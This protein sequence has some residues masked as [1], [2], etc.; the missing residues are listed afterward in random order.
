[1]CNKQFK[2]CDFGSATSEQVDLS[3]A[4]RNKILE[5]EEEFEKQTTLMYRPP[6]MID[7][8]AKRLIN[9]KV[10]IWMLGCVLYTL[11]YAQHPFQEG[12]QLAVVNSRYTIPEDT[13]FDD[14]FKGFIQAI[15]IPDPGSRP[16]I[17]QLIHMLDNYDN[18]NFALTQPTSTKPKATGPRKKGLDRDIT[19][20]EIEEEMRRMREEMAKNPNA[21]F[22]GKRVAPRAPV[23]R[24]APQVQRAAPPA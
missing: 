8:Y 15:L 24:Q 7:L 1:M 23:Q 11:A 2:F 4:D 19:D 20:A 5:C 22:R 6:E 10:D 18:L 9:H 13:R 12:T 3:L 14:K 17:N 16:D 21:D